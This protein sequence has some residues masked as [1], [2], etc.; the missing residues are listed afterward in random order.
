[1]I[2]INDALQIMLTKEEVISCLK[3]TRQRNF[4]DNLRIRHA[5]VQFDCKLRGYVGELAIRKWFMQKGIALDATNYL[6]DGN[7][8]DIDFLAKGKNIELKTSLIPD[9]D[10][11][12]SNVIAKRDIKL[13]KRGADNIEQLRGDIHLQIYYNQRTTKKDNWLK[14][15]TIDLLGDDEYLYNSFQAKCY[16]NSIFFVAWIDKPSLVKKINSLP[17]NQR[18]WSFRNSQRLFWNCKLHQSKKPVEIINYLN[19]L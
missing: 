13:I 18:C 5:N 4:I 2:T 9:S 10:G 3:K 1:M 16:L 12:L 7:N 14:S 19:S 11:D 6:E 15:Q 8:M 17:V